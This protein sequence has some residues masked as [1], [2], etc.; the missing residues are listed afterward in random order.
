M[1]VKMKNS[2]NDVT[3]SGKKEKTKAYK[4]KKSPNMY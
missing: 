2:L 4:E 3:K 1:L